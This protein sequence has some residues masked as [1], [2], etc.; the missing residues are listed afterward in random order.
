MKSLN[1]TLP[2]WAAA[3]ALGAAAATVTPAL[4]QAVPDSVLAER[5]AKQEERRAERQDGATR[6]ETRDERRQ[7][8]REREQLENMPRPVRRLLRAETEGATNVD[9]YKDKGE[10]KEPTAFGAKFTKADGHQ[11]DLRVDRE[12][13]VVSRT[14]LTAQAQQA[15]ARQ[16]P[17]TPAPAQPAPTPAPT[18]P[19]VAQQPTTPAPAPT[20]A[21][22]DATARRLQPNEIPANIRAVLDREAQGGTDVKYYRASYGHKPA[23]VVN[24]DVKGDERKVYVDDQG[25]VLTRKG[26]EEEKAQTASSREKASPSTNNKDDEKLGRVELNTMP[27]QVQTQFRRLTE[28]ASNVKFYRSKYGNQGAFQA[29]YTTKDGKD[30]KVYVDENGKIL[31]QKD[32]G[33]G[34]KD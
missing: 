23:Y 1:K 33:S 26:A 17:V 11:Y 6:Q 20:P 4:G 31:S 8:R 22:T 25:N 14:D 3:V 34:K 21:P 30:H 28:G 13:N 16:A 19:P 12:G 10:G 32:E 5:R 7:E 2:A 18:P 29:N 9:Y 15:A 27:K 24:W